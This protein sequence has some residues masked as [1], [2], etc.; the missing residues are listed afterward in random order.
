MRN[1]KT[2]GHA[3]DSYNI[4]LVL[5]KMSLKLAKNGVARSTNHGGVRLC[6]VCG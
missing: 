4:M 3:F 6:A 2:K 5:D 1:G